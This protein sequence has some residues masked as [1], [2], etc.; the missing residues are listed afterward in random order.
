LESLKRQKDVSVITLDN[1]QRIMTEVNLKTEPDKEVV[2]REI[3][4]E[5]KR[6]KLASAK[7]CI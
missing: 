5:Q 6:E 4:T 7:V 1:F 3:M 2:E